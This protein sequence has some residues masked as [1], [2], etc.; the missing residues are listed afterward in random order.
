MPTSSQTISKENKTTE[1][2]RIYKSL[3]WMCTWKQSTSQ[4]KPSVLT[5]GLLFP[6]IES[7]HSRQQRLSSSLLLP[8]RRDAETCRRREIRS[9]WLVWFGLVLRRSS[10]DGNKFIYV[11]RRYAVS[12]NTVK[13]NNNNQVYWHRVWLLNTSSQSAEDETAAISLTTSD[14]FNWSSWEIK[15]LPTRFIC[16]VRWDPGTMSEHEI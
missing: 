8:E 4:W 16:L 15:S 1:L 6:K 9:I 7:V 2:F 14:Y 13:T 11:S 5:C 12:S 10:V 3:E